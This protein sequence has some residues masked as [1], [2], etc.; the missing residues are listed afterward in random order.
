MQSFDP[1]KDNAESD[2]NRSE[3]S[4]NAALPDFGDTRIAFANKSDRE[5]KKT[6]W[7]FRMMNKYWLV[8]IGSAL[9]P[10]LV[11]LNIPLVQ[12][13]VKKTIFNQFCGGTTL[14]EC[15]STIRHLYQH[16]VLTILDYGVEGK[17]EEEE[18]NRAMREIIRAI[19]FAGRN[20]GAPI[21][22]T[23]VSGLARNQLLEDVQ[24][25]KKLSEAEQEEYR[26]VL[27]RLDSICH[28]A[29]ENNVGISIDAEESW[30]Q[31]PIDDM[32][33]LLMN[34]YNRDKIIVYN[35][36]QM[37]RT[38]R[39]EF[40]TESYKL[41]RTD[42]YILGAKLV[43]GAYMEKERDRAEERGYPSPIHPTKKATNEAYDAAL[44]FCLDHHEEIALI[45]ASH[46][47]DSNMLMAELILSKKLPKN[48]PH[49][50]FSQLY[51]MSDNLTFNLAHHG[52]LAAKYVPYGPVREVIPYLVRRTEENTSV[53][54]DMSREY[55]LV[56]EELKRRGLW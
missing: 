23:K 7:L 10:P 47:A 13:A 29:R 6:A 8:R 45:N 31:D 48:H 9:G 14:L 53:T 20:E 21:V 26:N 38:D 22:S 2:S 44:R 16:D 37:Y 52:F 5:L 46:N 28:V 54:G 56:Y 55:Q 32:V 35:T 11:R 15:K 36:F 18:F 39:L 51:G 24:A 17:D 1:Q 43:R 4:P 34:R 50:L 12:K 27:K 42:G 30:I 33:N 40:L 49:L 41:A 19:E 3:P 25:G